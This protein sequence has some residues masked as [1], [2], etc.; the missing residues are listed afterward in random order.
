MLERQSLAQLWSVLKHQHLLSK[1]TESERFGPLIRIFQLFYDG[2]LQLK[3]LKQL[4]QI[5][6]SLPRPL[7]NNYLAGCS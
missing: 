3:S 2:R 4:V 7:K 5:K 1:T 6:F